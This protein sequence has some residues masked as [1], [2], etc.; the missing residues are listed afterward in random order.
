MRYLKDWKI[1]ESTY[2]TEEFIDELRSRLGKYNLS[3]VEIREIIKR[4]DIQS[5][6]DGGKTPLN[7]ANELIEDMDLEGRGTNG[8]PP[9][10]VGRP[11]QSEI[12]YL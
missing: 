6:I 3:S 9:F 10:R 5:E 12:K 1:F 7:L 11:L 8:F 2:N 4:L